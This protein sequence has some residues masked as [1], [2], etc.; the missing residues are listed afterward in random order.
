VEPRSFRAIYVDKQPCAQTA[1]NYYE[2]FEEERKVKIKYVLAMVCVMAVANFASADTIRGINMDFVTIGSAGNPADTRAQANPYGCGSVDYNYRIGKYEVTHNQ[3]TAFLSLAGTPTGTDGGYSAGSTY[4][5]QMPVNNASWYEA[6]QFCNYL[7]SGDKSRGVYQF[8]GNNANPSSFLGINRAL[9]KTT[10]GITY[11][12]PT[13]DEWYKAA[14][15]K[16]DGSGYST[17]ANGTNTAPIAGVN[18]NYYDG[19]YYMGAWDV[20]S[21]TQEQN[22]TFDMM[23]NFWEWN[24]TTCGYV[25]YENS[26]VL[27]IRGG[28][29]VPYSDGDSLK[30][31]DRGY[32]GRE[33]EYYM[34]DF[35]VASDI[36][37]PC[38]LLLLGLGA[39]IATRKLEVKC[40]ITNNKL[41][42]QKSCGIPKG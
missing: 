41:R 35:R 18:S 34:L 32:I 31:S 24:E 29:W 22:G 13:E 26:P 2:F 5:G 4:Y 37:E 9:A 3:W 36:P 14:Y 19:V 8:S 38:T 27:G 25:G 10:Y 12:I 20:G 1:P 28:S 30:S 7:T 21:G 6:A 33:S 11:F 16:P 17:Y 42:N 23:G 40:P 39:A 15:Y